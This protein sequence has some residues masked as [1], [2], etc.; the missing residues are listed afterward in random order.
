M[1]VANKFADG[2]D[3]YHNKRVR[4]PKDDRPHRYSSYRRR[5]R[6]YDNQNSQNQVVA[7]YKGKIAKPKSVEATGNRD[8]SGSHKQF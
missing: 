1:D 7:G 4:S 5:S 8:D 6:N 3:V 2:E